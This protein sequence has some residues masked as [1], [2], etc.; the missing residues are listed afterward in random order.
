MSIK[1]TSAVWEQSRQSGGV[2]LILLALADH[3]DD[4]GY[5]YPS[6]PRLAKKGRMSVRNV[7]VI[8]E[9]LEFAGEI[10]REFNAGGQTGSGKT[11]RFRVLAGSS[12]YEPK[13]AEPRKKVASEAQ[14]RI[15]GDVEAVNPDSPLDTEGVNSDSPLKNRQA[16]N[17]C[18]PLNQGEGVNSGASRGELWIQ[19]G[20][21]QRSPRI[22]REPS[23]EP[24]AA[25][26]ALTRE[27]VP[28]STTTA[29]AAADSRSSR[30]SLTDAVPS[31]S[32][33]PQS[34]QSVQLTLDDFESMLPNKGYD[35]FRA[36]NPDAAKEFDREI[37]L[38]ASSSNP[39]CWPHCYF[40]DRIREMLRGERSVAVPVAGSSA[41]G[42]GAASRVTTTANNPA[43]AR[44][45]TDQEQRARAATQSA[46]SEGTMQ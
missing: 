33:G 46:P 42:M 15:G 22:I 29:A 7:Q 19:Q 43:Y 21:K 44:F 14:K 32:R 2:L 27:E 38:K 8:L 26:H 28:S 5:C 41:E 37:A 17:P 6:I 18:S 9:Q 4:Y 39:I 23:G 40:A 13:V 1:V 12:L 10:V 36:Q 20:V 35:A 25:A 24:S 34:K 11:N 3:A 31:A 16:V 45:V 30:M